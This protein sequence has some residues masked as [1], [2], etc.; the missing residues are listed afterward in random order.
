MDG[1]EN[2]CFG[3]YVTDGNIGESTPICDISE[4]NTPFD[5][6]EEGDAAGT[7]RDSG[8]EFFEEDSCGMQIELFGGLYTPEQLTPLEDG[9]VRIRRR[10][11]R[12]ICR[13]VLGLYGGL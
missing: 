5:W 2:P 13:L 1:I 12:M 10:V 11:F 6:C 8:P 4:N 9:F 7:F 3:V